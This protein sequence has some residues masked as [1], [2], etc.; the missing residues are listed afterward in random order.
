MC[1]RPEARRRRRAGP[2]ERSYGQTRHRER[3][4][5]LCYR[6]RMTASGIE[7]QLEKLLRAEESDVVS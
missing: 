4:A 3:S 1:P 7:L 2:L 6:D 5:T